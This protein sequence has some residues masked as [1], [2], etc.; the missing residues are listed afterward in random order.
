M[1]VLTISSSL[2]RE[3]LP[4]G[5]EAGRGR[6]TAGL[7]P[8]LHS[9]LNDFYC[10]FKYFSPKLLRAQQNCHP[11][12]SVAEGRDLRFLFPFSYT[13]FSPRYFSPELHG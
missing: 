1:T 6:E 13:L 4:S 5:V 3:S 9:G 10:R 2:Y 8:P 12:R 11:D 7:S